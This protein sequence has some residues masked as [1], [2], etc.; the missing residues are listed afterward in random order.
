MLMTEDELL[1]KSARGFASREDPGGG[2]TLIVDFTQV[3]EPATLAIGSM[4]LVMLG[5]LRRRR[6]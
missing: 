4:G 6:M 5:W 3:P 1:R 2:P